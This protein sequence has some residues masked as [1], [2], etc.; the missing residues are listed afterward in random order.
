MN[1][2]R[3]LFVPQLPGFEAYIAAIESQFCPFLEPSAT[4]GLTSYS[5]YE[6]GNGDIEQI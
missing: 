6:L 1:I 3:S 2:F 4:R 5:V